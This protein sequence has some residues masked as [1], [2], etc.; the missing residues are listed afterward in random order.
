MSDYRGDKLLVELEYGGR[1][2]PCMYLFRIVNEDV[3]RACMAEIARYGGVEPVVD[4]YGRDDNVLMSEDDVYYDGFLPRRYRSDLAAGWGVRFYL[5]AWEA[6]SYY[7]FDC[8]DSIGAG[9]WR[10][11]VKG[12]A[13]NA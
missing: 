7:G 13:V 1:Y 12:C 8:G 10:D 5:D 9:A 3:H 2:A 4:E 6:C 11:I